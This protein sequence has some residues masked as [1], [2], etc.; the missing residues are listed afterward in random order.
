[1]EKRVGRFGDKSSLSKT[2]ADL[3]MQEINK[4]K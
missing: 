4:I 1:M 2:T 3:N